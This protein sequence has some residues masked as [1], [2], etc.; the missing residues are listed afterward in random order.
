M[1]KR[2]MSFLNKHHMINTGDHILVGVSGGADSVCLLLILK[3]LQKQME[4]KLTAVHVEHGIRGEASLNDAAFTEQFCREQDVPCM[5]YWEDAPK[6]AAEGHL[7]LEEAARELRYACFRKACQEAG[8]NKI[9]TAHHADDNAETVLFHLCRGTGIQGLGGIAPVRGNIIRPLLCIGR[10][11]IEQILSERG[12]GYCT[13]ATNADVTYSRNRIR[14]NLIPE[15]NTVNRQAVPHIQRT[16]EMLAEIGAYL[17]HASWEAGKQ[18]V[19]F[20]LSGDEGHKGTADILP[21]KE[22]EGEDALSSVSEKQMEGLYGVRI[23]KKVVCSLD[24]V[25]AKNLLHQLIGLAAGG[26]K[27]ISYTHIK[28]VYALFTSQPGKE[29][30]LPGQLSA[31]SDY[32]AVLLLK[33]AAGEPAKEEAAFCRTILKIPGKT[34]YLGGFLFTTE[35]FGFDGDCEK[36]PQKTCTKWLDYDKI[37][38]DISIRGR[39]T[40]DYFQINASGGHKKL[41]EYFIQEKIPQ[42]QRQKIPLLACGSHVLWVVGKRISEACKVTPETKRILEISVEWDSDKMTDGEDGGSSK[43][44]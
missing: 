35:V 20:L 12:Q 13:D 7:T 36:I 10:N 33:T 4:F 15:L 23:E 44:G 29:A 22:T 5:I 11:D 14:H 19:S 40:G 30:V 32:D 8:A 21:G 9:A 1:M 43:D 25:L 34:V 41:K 3:E 39:L 38:E 6:K 2:V 37:D 31:K 16:S 28:S 42:A 18:G 27:D 24:P 17:E 26:R